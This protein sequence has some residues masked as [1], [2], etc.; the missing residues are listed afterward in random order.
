M[1][2]HKDTADSIEGHTTVSRETKI[3][4]QETLFTVN[5]WASPTH[6]NHELISFGATLVF[7]QLHGSEFKGR[8]RAV[9]IPDN[10]SEA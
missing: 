9:A 10:I 3:D 8:Y 4:L 7:K 5:V 2:F 1:A 6:K